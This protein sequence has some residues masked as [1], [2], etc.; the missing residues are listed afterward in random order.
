VGDRRGAGW[1]LQHLAWSATTRGDYELAERM[2]AVAGDVFASLDDDGGMSWCAG[3]EAFVRL[4]QGRHR[5][6]RELARSLLPLGRAMG[7]RLGTAACLTIDGF[8]AAELGDIDV[9]LE[10]CSAAYDDFTALGDT[11]GRCMALTATG[12]A[13]R[14]QGRHRKAGRRLSEA[15]E[16]ARAENHPAPAALA[17]GVLGYLRLDLGDPRGA[18]RAADE[19]LEWMSSLDVRDSAVAGLR[20]LR[21]QALLATGEDR[22]AALELLRQARAVSD[23]SLLFPRRAGLSHL[24]EA[25]LA[26]GEVGAA[27]AM[28]HEAMAEPAEDL[29]S[30]VVALRVLGA[31]LVAAGDAPAGRFAVRQSVALARATQLR[32]ELPASQQALQSLA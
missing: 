32:A 23:A 21:A 18:G 24:A 12:V 16:L 15:I 8:A 1:A 9:A 31:C 7:D 11:W 27:L 13:L 3:T 22:G 6:A 28:S 26:D 2:L 30:R 20:V 25:L 10:Q 4:M 29:R 19:A 14:G 17:L 5:E